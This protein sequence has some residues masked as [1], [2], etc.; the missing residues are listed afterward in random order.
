MLEQTVAVEGDL[1]SV[2][3]L[4]QAPVTTGVDSSSERW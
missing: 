1:D 3:G 4:R 2:P